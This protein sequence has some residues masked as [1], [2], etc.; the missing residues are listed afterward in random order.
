M[1]GARVS[2]D[3]YLVPAHQEQ[4]HSGPVDAVPLTES[5]QDLFDGES[6]PDGYHAGCPIREVDAAVIGSLLPLSG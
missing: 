5:R 2:V 3:Q 4:V 1:E 6:R